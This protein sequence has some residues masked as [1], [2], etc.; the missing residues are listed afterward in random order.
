MKIVLVSLF[1]WFTCSYSVAQPD[2][3]QLLNSSTVGSSSSQPSETMPRQTTPASAT[4]AELNLPAETPFF[5]NKRMIYSSLWAFSSL[6]YLYADIA[7]LM[8]ANL[9]AQYETGVVDGTKIS[10]QFL[11]IAAGF[12]QIPIAN[13]FLPHVIKNERTLRWIQ[14]A[15]GTV[16]TL[17][18]SATLFAGK[19]TPYYIVFSG[20]EIAATTYITIDAI[21]W[22]PAAK[23]AHVKL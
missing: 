11:A 19:P 9:H 13:V 5:R 21:R 4:P 23:R 2:T 3:N 6:N 7:G 14:I 18:Q 16:M 8:D 20:F 17:V 22:K 1:C 10:P 15:S 12:M